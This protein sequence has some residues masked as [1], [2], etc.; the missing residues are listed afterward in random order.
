MTADMT[1]SQWLELNFFKPGMRLSEVG[2]ETFFEEV[3]P[4]LESGELV[5]DNAEDFTTWS[6]W[7]ERDIETGK[8]MYPDEDEDKDEMENE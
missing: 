1:L 4:L 5:I 2:V 3:E 6:E 8:K 7:S